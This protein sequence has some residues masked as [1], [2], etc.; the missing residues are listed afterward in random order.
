MFHVFKRDGILTAVDTTN[1]VSVGKIEQ[2]L[3]LC[4]WIRGTNYHGSS[5]PTP[6]GALNEAELKGNWAINE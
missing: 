3:S 1:C 6:E 4:G 5:A 2:R